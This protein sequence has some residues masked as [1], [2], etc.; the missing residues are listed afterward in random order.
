MAFRT[1]TDVITFDVGSA[2]D[3]DIAVSGSALTLRMGSEFVT[4]VTTD[5]LGQ[6][7]TANLR[8]A[9]GSLLLIGDDSRSTGRDDAANTLI[10]GAGNDRL[11]GLGGNDTVDGREGSDTYVVMGANDGTD[12]YRDTGTT[13]TDRIVAGANGAVIN[14]GTS[15][16]AAASGIEAISGNGYAGVSV[17]GSAA[18]DNLNFSGLTLS[19]LALID[20]G[21]G[22]DNVVGSAGNNTI[23]GGAG[24]DR[25]DGGVG[26]DTG[27]AVF[28]GNRASYV[29]TNSGAIV[30]VRDT[31]ALA[32][33]D[34]GTDTLLNVEFVSFLDGT[35]SLGS[36]TAVAD[37]AS[38]AAG[39][40]ATPINV[41]ANDTDIDV[42]DSQRV[43]SVQAPL[44]DTTI[45]SL[46]ETVLDAGQWDRA[47]ENVARLF[48]ASAAA[49]FHFD[50]VAQLPSRFR[51][52]GHS[53]EVQR[54]YQSYYHRLDPGRDAGMRARV[55]EW[56]A[57][58]AILD[59]R[60]PHCQEYVQDFALRSG[61]GHGAGFKVAGDS[62]ACVFLG[63]QRSPDAARFGEQGRATF[64]AIAPHLHRIIRM[65]GR[66]DELSS[67][68]ALARACLDRLQSGVL[69]V[70][71]T[72]RVVYVNAHGLLLLN[73]GHALRI[74]NQ[75][76]TRD[77]ASLDEHLA[78]AVACAC[79]GLP[80]GSALRVPREG[81]H[82]PLLL[83]VLPIPAANDLARLHPEPLALVLLDEPNS[84]LDGAGEQA[85]SDALEALKGRR[86]W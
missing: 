6:F 78:R 45:S 32:N 85:L 65:Q 81:G 21:G 53:L 36:P 86:R 24:N 57:D 54:N 51:G 59:I 14:L 1:R 11:I 58:E 30:Q 12:V 17:A 10:G 39:S 76:L 8:L 75:H 69:V 47:I 61:I 84:N 42:G 33:G 43:V 70:D 9:D 73:V 64:N 66:I 38:V 82:P 52:Y 72:R 46:Y 77:L 15:F 67:G 28:S 7:S 27:T 79:T 34:D 63:L 62:S 18:A 5:T 40:G 49:M 55:G 71:K 22:A 25:I 26:T 2:S 48:S 13:G 31:D 16:S 68:L 35:F 80:T 41:L 20:A 29:V 50:F 23:K 44:F 60:A 19:G 4:L 74:A 3:L 56:V 83:N 37:S